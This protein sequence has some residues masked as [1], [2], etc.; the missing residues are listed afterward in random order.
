[1]GK[2]PERGGDMMKADALLDI[3]S[4]SEIGQ[5]MIF[6]NSKMKAKFL[7][8]FV[9]AKIPCEVIH[10]DLTQTERS[11]VVSKF[12]NGECRCLIAT[13]LVGRGIDIQQLSLVFNFD[14]PR[15][16][17]KSSY[18]HRIG[19]AGRFGRRGKAVNFIFEDELETIKNIEKHYR[20]S[21]SP[22]PRDFN[23]K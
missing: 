21:I 19:R 17:D 12:R 14:I 18:I 16:T 9:S 6:V 11:E 23:L 8:N 15:L 5:S 2:R 22:L 7:H 1:M 10:A 13:G 20:T 4:Q 3:F